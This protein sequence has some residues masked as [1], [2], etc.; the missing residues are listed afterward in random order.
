MILLQA[1]IREI[2]K[3]YHRKSSLQ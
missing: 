1:A 3:K 2:L